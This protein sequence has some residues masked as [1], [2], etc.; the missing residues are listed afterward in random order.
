MPPSA[1]ALGPT[2]EANL[3][4]ARRVHDINFWG[5]WACCK[6]GGAMMIAA[7]RGTVLN[8][9]SMAS[10]VHPPFGAAY[11]SSKAAVESMTHS[12]RV[13]LAPFGIKVV[14]AAPTWCATPTKDNSPMLS[15]EDWG[16][17]NYGAAMEDVL[18]QNDPNQPGAWPPERI[19][20]RVVAAALKRRPPRVVFGGGQSRSFRFLVGCFSRGM[21]D[22]VLA[23]RLGLGKVAAGAAAAGAVVAGAV[24]VKSK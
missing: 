21:V 22:R 1:G 9:G 24:A 23:G 14:Y 16:R 19:A 18:A 20:A 13:E 4:V 12:L 15:A 5:A 11:S 3:A 10:R 17:G 2:T 6:A 7:R 8:I